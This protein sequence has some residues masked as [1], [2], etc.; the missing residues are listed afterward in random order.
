MQYPATELRDNF[1]KFSSALVEKGDHM[2]LQDIRLSYNYSKQALNRLSIQ[3]LQFYVYVNNVGIVWKA[4]KQGIDPDNIDGIPTP[5][6]IAG[7][8]KIDFK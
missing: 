5:L 1:Y 6:T 7:G 8:I 2:R 3:S 4:N